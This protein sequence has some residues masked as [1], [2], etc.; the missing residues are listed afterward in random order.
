MRKNGYWGERPCTIGAGGFTML[1]LM[2]T[3]SIVAIL[4]AISIPAIYRGMH[5]LNSRQDADGLSGRLRLARS[6]ALTTFSDVVVYFGLDG[7]N[8]YTVHLDNGGGTG[9]PDDP[10]YV[11][12][13]RNN[14]S[15]DANELV[16]QPIELREGTVFGYIPGGM[17]S[18]GEALTEAISLPGDP[19]RLTFRA[20]GTADTNGSVAL[21]P[22]MDFLDQ[23]PGRDFLVEIRSSTG[24][25]KVQGIEY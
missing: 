2:A 23:I 8:T 17:N 25:I 4:L 16:K 9:L 24:E 11:T 14:G 6:Q 15:I 18:A 5:T 19:P 13:N 10:D 12:A 21:L 1:E 22:L 20:D 3:V 7:A